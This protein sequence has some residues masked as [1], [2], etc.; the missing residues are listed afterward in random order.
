MDSTWSD[1]I[2]AGTLS[3]RIQLIQTYETGNADSPIGEKVVTFLQNDGDNYLP[4]ELIDVLAANNWRVR[5]IESQDYSR[6]L[7]TG[8]PGQPDA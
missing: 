3:K 1:P 7:D 8:D 4:N 6:T 5:I 2:P